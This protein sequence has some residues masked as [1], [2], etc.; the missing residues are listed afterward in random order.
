VKR[1]GRPRRQCDWNSEL[2]ATLEAVEQFC[3]DFHRW[4]A[5]TCAELNLF[6]AT[7]LLREVLTNSVIHGCREDPGKRVSLVL[8]V[9]PGRLIVAIRDEGKGFDWRAVWDRRPD[10]ADVSGRGISILRQYA[11]SVRFN[12][13]GN[14]VTMIR[15]F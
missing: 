14:C 5:D 11:N 9:K 3:L 13:A 2:P 7:L 12:R 6:A 15:T 4:C 8:R 1:V 10:I